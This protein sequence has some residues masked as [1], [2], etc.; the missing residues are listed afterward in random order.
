MIRKFKAIL[1]QSILVKLFLFYL[2]RSISFFYSLRRVII[3]NMIFVEKATF[4]MYL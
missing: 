1:F 3:L 2:L 4:L